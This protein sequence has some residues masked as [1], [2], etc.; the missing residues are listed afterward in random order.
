MKDKLQTWCLIIGV[1]M[2][3]PVFLVLPITWLFAGEIPGK[4]FP[5]LRAIDNPVVFYVATIAFIIVAMKMTQVSLV[6]ARFFYRQSKRQGKN[7]Q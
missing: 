7:L 4:R 5:F 2:C 3:G 6:A 1:G